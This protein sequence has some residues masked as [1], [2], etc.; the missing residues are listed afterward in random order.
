VRRVSPR[1]S[2]ILEAVTSIPVSAARIVSGVADATEAS[3]R[4]LAR[5][6][7]LLA[8]ATVVSQA[9]EEPA[10][11]L[12]PGLVRLA[13]LLESGVLEQ[14]STSV[15]RLVSRA[16]GVVSALE[17]PL[18]AALAVLNDQTVGRTLRLLERLD[19]GLP[20]AEHESRLLR[21]TLER[22]LHVLESAPM[23]MAGMPAATLMRLLG[24]TGALSEGIPKPAPGEPGPA[25]GE[26]EDG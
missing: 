24:G 21:E 1:P 2:E 13:Q 17:G 15:P 25:A 20:V 16:D 8:S 12:A 4:V 5:W 18:P 23:R 26:G 10:R 3:A 14:I 6:E 19:A 22:L 9:L 7:E 11:A